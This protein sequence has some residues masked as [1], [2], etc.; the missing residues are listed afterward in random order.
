MSI[1]LFDKAVQNEQRARE[2]RNLLNALK[3]HSH[4]PAIAE[5]PAS[6]KLAEAMMRA[7]KSE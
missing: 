4:D 6:A 1:N 2:L 3:P 5:I 7:Q